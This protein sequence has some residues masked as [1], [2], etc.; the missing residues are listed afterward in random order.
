MNLDGV[1]LARLTSALKKTLARFS[2]LGF[3]HA[4]HWCC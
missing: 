1:R 4:L 3:G 2:F